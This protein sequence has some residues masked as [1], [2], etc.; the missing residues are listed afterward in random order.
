MPQVND[1][2]LLFLELNCEIKY[3]LWNWRS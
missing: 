1:I 3:C 2:V